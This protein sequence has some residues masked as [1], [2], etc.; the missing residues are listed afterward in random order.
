MTKVSVIIPLYNSAR[1]LPSL[2]E[3]IAQQTVAADLEFIFIDD[4]G[5]DDSLA[6]ARS[7]AA[8]SGLKCVF[9]ATPA[10][11]G[12]GAARNVGLKMAGGEYVAFLD[13]DDALDPTFCEKLFS[14]AAA[15]D[16]DLAYCNILAVK[17]AGSSVWCNPAVASGDFDREKRLYFLK[18]YKSYFTSFIYR[19][20]LLSREGI[21][22]P[23][24]RS[25]ED[26]C[27]LTCALLCAR[28][29]ACVDEPLYIYQM[30]GDSL[31]L[32]RLDGRHMQRLASFD[33]LLDFARGKNLYETYREMLD[34]LYVKKGAVGA[35]RNAPLA[36][37]EIR[38]HCLAAVPDFRRSR[39]WKQDLKLRTAALILL[40]L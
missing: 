11:G 6:A 13:S 22:F 31:S 3:N 27:F 25:A 5:G 8:S 9:G 30:R 39:F 33:A 12:P 15:C 1:F 17:G 29:I 16:A 10:N 37:R 14:A 36:R 35:A 28:S 40:G 21:A 2:F 26:S 7:L 34:Y 20:S 38:G 24:T 18:N 4:H 19:R 32:G 23:A